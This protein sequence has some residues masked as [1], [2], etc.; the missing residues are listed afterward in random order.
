MMRYGTIQ[1]RHYM[2]TV[3]LIITLL[4]LCSICISAPQ[5]DGQS[6][7]RQ[8]RL[9]PVPSNVA[10]HTGR[11]KIDSSFTVLVKGHSD[12]R[13]EAAIHR[14]ARRLQGRTGFELSHAVVAD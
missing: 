13:L 10:F 4:L 11:L 5:S 12:D 6:G 8:H 7:S 3:E 1:M 14:V 2:K 9:M